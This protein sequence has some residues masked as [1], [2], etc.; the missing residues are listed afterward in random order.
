MA[1]A[2]PTLADQAE[3][4]QAVAMMGRVLPSGTSMIFYRPEGKERVAVEV[5]GPDGTTV[6]HYT[7][8]IGH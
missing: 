7:D 2:M 5:T 6:T 1:D 3:L 4:D 8:L